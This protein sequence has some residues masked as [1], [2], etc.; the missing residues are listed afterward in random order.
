MRP[1]SL[2]N[3]VVMLTALLGILMACGARTGLENIATRATENGT[4]AQA[5]GGKSDPAPT[6]TLFVETDPPVVLLPQPCGSSDA[7]ALQPSRPSE[8]MPPPVEGSKGE[9]GNGRHEEYESCD[10]GNSV[11]GDGCG[12]TCQIEPYYVCPTGG[13][14]CVRL[15]ICGDNSLSAS[16]GCDDGNLVSGDGCSPSC[17]PEIACAASEPGCVNCE[18]LN[19]NCDRDMK[20]LC[21]NGTVQ[22]EA[23]EVCDHGD[24]NTSAYGGC[25]E[26]CSLSARCGDLVIQ[27]CGQETCD[28]GNRVGGDGCSAD[29][30]REQSWVR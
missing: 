2:P 8:P 18:A 17:Q 30:K 27:T 23:G 25:T 22:A 15:E 14:S 5:D 29:C 1:N 7:V 10:D 4:P 26:G 3:A 21:G 13:Q 11:G 24:G 28:D 6:T 9:C 12:A 16:E 19:M 20:L